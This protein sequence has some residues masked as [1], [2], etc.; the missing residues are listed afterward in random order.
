M[1][2][3]NSG[4]RNLTTSLN[5]IPNRVA[6]SKNVKKN[7]TRIIHRIEEKKKTEFEVGE[8][9]FIFVRYTTWSNRGPLS[10]GESATNP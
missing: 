1:C 10:T 7:N 2:L 8:V 5:T 3:P 9:F 6:A 4:F